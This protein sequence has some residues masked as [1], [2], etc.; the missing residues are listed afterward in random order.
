MVSMF[1]EN[2]NGEWARVGFLVHGE[3][4]E[5]LLGA[6]WDFGEFNF[7]YTAND[8]FCTGWAA[9]IYPVEWMIKSLIFEMVWLVTE[10]IKIIILC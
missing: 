10:D 3:E 2:D 5:N 7:I 1:A 4:N 8:F 6:T 9:E